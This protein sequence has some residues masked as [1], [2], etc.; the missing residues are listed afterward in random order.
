MVSFSNYPYV[1]NPRNYHSIPHDLTLLLSSNQRTLQRQHCGQD[2]TI[3]LIERNY[4]HQESICSSRLSTAA[5]FPRDVLLGSTIDSKTSFSVF[6]DILSEIFE[7]S[8]L[9]ISGKWQKLSGF[10][11]KCKIWS[12]DTFYN[13]RHI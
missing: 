8:S 11:Y 5:S 2:P 13:I 6:L 10:S 7:G 4:V 1:K 12:A 3:I 9:T